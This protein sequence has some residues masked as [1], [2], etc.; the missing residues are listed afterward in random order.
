MKQINVTIGADGEVSIDLSG[1]KGKGCD[2]VLSD[3]LGDDKP[4]RVE[5]KREYH[6]AA[7]TAKEVQKQ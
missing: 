1:Y 4:T 3:F 5:T 7:E 6:Q 2:K